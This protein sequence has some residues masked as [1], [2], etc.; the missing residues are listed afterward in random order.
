[1]KNNLNNTYIVD[2]VIYSNG[3]SHEGYSFIRYF[4][5]RNNTIKSFLDIGCGNGILLKAIDKKTDYLGLDANAGIY[6]KKISK[7]IKYFKNAKSTENYFSKIKKKYECVALMDVLEHT[8][9]FLKLFKIALK[10]SSKYVVVGLPNEDYLI[11]RIRFLIG[12]GILTHGLEMINK[13]PGHKHQWFI[14]YKEAVPLLNKCAKKNKFILSS[15]M[16]YVGQPNNVFKRFLYKLVIFFIPTN[17]K[18]NNFC[19]VFKKF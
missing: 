3:Y 7:K 14:Q 8:D 17:I 5:K 16:F 13:K 2:N 12:K 15:Q 1:M 10:K 4:L 6:K 18:M 9:T 11:A 19:L